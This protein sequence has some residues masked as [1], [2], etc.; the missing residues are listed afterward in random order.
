MRELLSKIKVN[1]LFWFVVG[2][3]VFTGYF[4]EVLMIFTIVFIH[5]MGHAIAAHWFK[6]RINKIELLPF[7]GVAEVEDPGNR[8][9][10]EE[11]IV[12]IAG[13]LQHVWMMLLSYV[14]VH[15]SFWTSTDHHLFVWHNLMILVFNL[16]PILPL[17]GG[18]LVQ[19]WCTYRYPYVRALTISRF[20][21][22]TC[23]AVLC[24]IS[25][26]FFPYH[27]NLWVVLTFLFLTNYLEWKQR[28]YRFMRFLMARRTSKIEYKEKNTVAIRDS[29]P[30]REAMKQIKRGHYH[31]FK[32]FQLQTGQSLE[33]EEKDLIQL[34][35]TN[36]KPQA[37]LSQFLNRP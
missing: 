37:P 15:F 18:R 3:G 1:P 28:H 21:S 22:G 17:D 10:H 12:I 36:K 5:E 9:F 29:L 8:P 30:L 26:F 34:L 4:R 33:I 13:P 16:L 24:G 7:G 25:L 19:L 23:L 14:L 35:F 11:L 20:A 31:L 32:V 27:L 2:I 6:W